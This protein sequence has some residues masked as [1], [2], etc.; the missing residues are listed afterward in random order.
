VFVVP[1]FV[2]IRPNESLVLLFAGSYLGT[3][4]STGF[5]WIVPFTSRQRVS[6]RVNNFNTN[7]TKVNDKAGNPIEIAA[8][9]VWRVKDSA[10]AVLNVNDYRDF[11]SVQ[12]ETAVRSL[13]SRFPY[14][15]EEGA[16]SLRGSPEQISSDLQ[17]ELAQRLEIA[18]V[19]VLEARLSH[20][21][22]APEI[23]VAMLRKQQAEA[24][25]RARRIITANAVDIVEQAIKALG[26]GGVVALNDEERVR[27]V[28]NLLV[29]LVSERDTT[30]VLDLGP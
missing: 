15:S 20:L 6:R 22:Y 12:G 17:N 18:G 28:N 27:L 3:V 1:G 2:V 13:A 21:A 26:E 23:A 5:Y 7:T 9:I 25:V 24:V 14:D 30:P 4:N 8:V 19:E 16:E 10:R 29:A 11:V